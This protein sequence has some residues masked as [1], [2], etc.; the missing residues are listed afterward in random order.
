MKWLLTKKYSA[1]II[2]LIIGA[3]IVFFYT[4]CGDSCVY[5]QG[6]IFGIELQYLGIIYVIIL[7]VF[8]ILKKG[9]IVLVLLSAGVGVEVFL[10]GYQV[11]NNTYCSYCLVFAALI[12]IQF[13]LN[14]DWSWK[15]LILTF[16]I[17]GFF[18]F[19]IFFEGSAFPVYSGTI[20][21]SAQ[22][23]PAFKAV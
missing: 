9:L 3:G 13:F 21:L 20:N 7:I 12:F 4:L 11:M 8:N 18:C 1:N 19:F 5:L 17:L 6:R 22:T 16:M 10:I 14:L 23:V 2:L 15:L